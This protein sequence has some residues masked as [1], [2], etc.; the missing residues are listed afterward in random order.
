MI[1]T[2]WD[3]Q[4]KIG[5]D[6]VEL[7][8]TILPWE[9]HGMTVKGHRPWVTSFMQHLASMVELGQLDRVFSPRQMVAE[10]INCSIED[11]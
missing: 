1:F 8:A 9:R 3:L 2:R 7:Q 11:I 6:A 5:L 10:Y 4:M